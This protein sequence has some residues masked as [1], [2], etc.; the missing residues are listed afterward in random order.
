M[1]LISKILACRL[2]SV[3]SSIVNENQVAYVN[4]RFISESGRLIFDVLKITNSSDIEEML[5]TVDIEKAFDFINHSLLMCVLKKFGFG[6]DFR[7]WIQILMKNLES[8]VINGGKTTPYFKLER[9][10][11]LVIALEVVFSLIK[12]NP[13]I[14]SLQ[15]FSH[16]FLYSAYADDTTFFLRNRKSATEVIK[17]F[18]KFSPFSEL[19]INNAKCE[20]AGIGV[21]K[22][23]KIALCGMDCINL[24]EDI[25]KI[26]GIY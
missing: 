6:N 16:M 23:V 10:T 4:N 18:D 1:K 9:G 15:F 24:T 8:R 21:K 20:T 25:I 14:K 26:L 12:A 22:G 2:K 17:T 19:K 5:M 13:D 3:F 7:K 11:R